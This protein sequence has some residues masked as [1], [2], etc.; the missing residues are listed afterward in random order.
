MTMFQGRQ[1]TLRL[2]L[3]LGDAVTVQPLG[4]LIVPARYAHLGAA[5]L[6]LQISGAMAMVRMAFLLPVA[7]LCFPLNADRM[8]CH[9][10]NLLSMDMVG[11]GLPYTFVEGVKQ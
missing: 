11:W 8:D 2:W 10:K 1:A 9:L 4:V 6:L 7:M 3:K 5:M